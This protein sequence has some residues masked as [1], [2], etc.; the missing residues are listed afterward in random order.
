MCLFVSLLWDLLVWDY[1][2]P[3]IVTN[4][5]QLEFFFFSTFCRAAFV[6]KY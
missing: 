4:F 2:F 3:V 5:L 1:L 6:D